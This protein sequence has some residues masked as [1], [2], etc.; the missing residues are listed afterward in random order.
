MWALSACLGVALVSSPVAAQLDVGG[1]AKKAA[2][3]AG[4]AAK[5]EAFKK[6]NAK[7]LEEGRKN[8]CS[9]KSD[10]DQL[11]PGCDSK[12]KKLADELVQAKKQLEAAGVKS[13][14]FEVS[15]HTDTSGKPEHNKELSSKRAAV[16]AKELVGKGIP[17]KEI[18]SIGMGAD[19]PLVTP[20]NTDAKKKKNRRYEIQVRS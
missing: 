15:G 19:K 18:I 4:G 11:M 5:D 8:Q 17:E 16:I 7:L 13:Y 20:D 1:L 12:I 14:K 9:F 6:V 2:T 3:T 10:S